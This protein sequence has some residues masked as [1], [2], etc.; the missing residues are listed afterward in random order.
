[1]KRFRGR[2]IIAATATVATL[3]AAVVAAASAGVPPPPVNDNYVDSLVIPITSTKTVKDVRDVTN[4]TV[5]PN[6]FNPCGASSCPT[7]PA[8]TTTCRGAA[9]SH[10]VW[11]DFHPKVDGTIRIRTSGYDN[12]ITVY[13]YNTRTFVPDVAHKICVHQG[14]FPSQELD[15]TVKKGVAYTIQ[16]GAVNPPVAQDLQLEFLFDYFI[17]PPH[18]LQAQVSLSVAASSTNA[19]IVSLSVQSSH[20]THVNV[21]CGNFCRPQNADIGRRG[22]TTIPFNKLKGVTLPLGTKLTVRVTAPNSIGYVAQYTVVPKNVN[23]VTFCT[24][25]GKRKL[26]KAGTCH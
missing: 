14:D 21:T 19:S 10:T 9:Y 20:G 17:P 26:H 12:A 4:A 3:T 24:E 23:K 1:M 8:E 5:Q 15:T 22:A 13:T 16:V 7:G 11:Y 6:L 25:P 2:T 18:V